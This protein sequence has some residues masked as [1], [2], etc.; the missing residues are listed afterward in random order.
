[1][2]MTI[3]LA[4]GPLPVPV[5]L[6]EGLERAQELAAVLAL[7]ALD[8]LEQAVAVKAEGF[9]VLEGEEQRERAEVAVGGNLGPVAVDRGRLERAACLVEGAAKRS[10]ANGAAR[11]NPQLG[12][13]SDQSR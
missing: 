9:V 11:G 6:D 10:Q 1:M 13:S 8:R 2:P 4:R 12:M 5:V 3:E 7:A